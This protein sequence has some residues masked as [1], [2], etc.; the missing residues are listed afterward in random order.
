MRFLIILSLIFLLLSCAK[1]P[2]EKV[3]EAIDVAQSFLSKGDCEGAYKV[4]T[5][6][7]HQSSDA[8][9]LQVLASVYGCRAS[10]SDL[11]I[12]DAL[13]NAGIDTTAAGLMK[14]LAVLSSSK[15]E[16]RADSTS[17]VAMR[18]GLNILLN[19]D[20]ITQP[21]Q[22]ERN[23]KFG[24][25]KAGDLG[26]Q[27]LLMSI[28][29]MGKF[30]N[31]YGNVNTTGVKGGGAANTDEQT[32]PVSTC[33]LSYTG[34]ASTFIDLGTNL[35]GACR[36]T[37][38]V[39]HP[40]LSTAAADLPVTKRR[41]CEGLTLLTNIIDVISNIPLSSNSSFAALDDVKELVADFKD[42]ATGVDPSLS[43]LL[44]TTSQK[45]CEEIVT[46]SAEFDRLQYIYAL[47]FETGLQ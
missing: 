31:F 16:K 28:A 17:Y 46:S 15:V 44:E 9:Y 19:D 43:T 36:S 33:F 10:Y 34:N 42:T 5:E 4:L 27:V 2:G 3:A 40:N 23:A 22:S 8:N 30:L 7:G 20:G 35:G 1:A 39:S 11:I 37:A 47:I 41:L 6:V 12:I 14:S 26:M 29:Q 24:S 18:N 38:R 25:R 21:S 13:E 32:S 45:K